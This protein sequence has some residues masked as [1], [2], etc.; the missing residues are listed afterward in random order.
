M[1]YRE[2]TTLERTREYQKKGSRNE[3]SGS[4]MNVQEQFVESDSTESEGEEEYLE[5]QKLDNSDLPQE[6]WQIQKL[7]KYMK[8]G[9]PSAT[10]IALCSLRDLNLQQQTCQLAIKDVGGLEIL[11]NLLD[12][13]D[14]CC[15]IG[16]LQILREI[17]E[18]SYIRRCIGD[19]GGLQL[20][21]NIV[22]SD[23]DK[24]LKAL[25]AET[26]AN[27]AKFKRA[28]RAV[29][30]AN[31]IKKLVELLKLEQGESEADRLKH[32]KME[33]SSISNRNGSIPN[34]DEE[35]TE[36]NESFEVI[37]CV[38][39]ALWSL[40]KS[41]MN[42][43]SM[44]R[45]GIIPLIA[46][47]LQHPS[48]T[49][50]IPIVG[51]LQVC[52][53]ELIYRHAVRQ[54]NM[55]KDLIRL[56]ATS[57]D[58]QLIKHCAW[59]IFKCA[60]DVEV[61]RL[62]REENGLKPLAD[63]LQSTNNNKDLLEA[64]TGAIWKCALCSEN[65][66]EFQNYKLTDTLV[67]LLNDQPEEVLINVV[68]ALGECGKI[69]ENRGIIRRANGI[70]LLV[71]QLT[72]TNDD[73]LVNLCNSIQQCAEDSENMVVIDRQDGVRYLW[74]LLKNPNRKV[75]A[76]AA[77]AI[78]PCIKTTKDAGELVRSFV[79][80]LELIVSLL[81]SPDDE[82]LAA[83]C[84]AISYIARD[85]ENLAVIT[86]HG[87]VHSLAK[88]TSTNDDNLRRYLADAVCE[89]CQWNKNREQ[90]G[91]ENAVEPFVRYLK[92]TNDIC[93]RRST[94]KALHQLSKEAHNCVAMHEA[95]AV[96]ALINLVPSDDNELQEA[97]AG[98]ISNIRR[99]ALANDRNG[100]RS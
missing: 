1:K 91:E 21:I 6:Y 80:G 27:V 81:D 14:H 55:V 99:L 46:K 10:L 66:R 38:A 51:T 75:Q 44:R 57:K 71:R 48:E 61:R 94:A 73:L 50:C 40:S 96:K 12:T 15:K 39:L 7:V 3:N 82:V 37:R 24:R 86:D 59:A 77:R 65:V 35:N 19:L 43:E 49:V 76:A 88:L 63:L 41:T 87:V 33:H 5:K 89:C 31:G 2:K 78:C 90:F 11:I 45:A 18:N 52:S 13:Q 17:S 29:R 74:S 72:G 83:V 22:S 9:N 42:K 20:M 23:D 54:E 8:G 95:G 25:A 68:G 36:M 85:Q 62:V 16:S 100:N 98:C 69:P 92:A 60:E 79:G 58:E 56:M 97:S 64:L 34:D 67:T 32:S 93:V 30:K 53:S 4:R 28:R 84:S 26:I 47:L 70:Q